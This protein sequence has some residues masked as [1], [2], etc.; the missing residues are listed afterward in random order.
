MK[1]SKANPVI[2]LVVNL[3]E[4]TQTGVVLDAVKLRGNLYKATIIGADAVLYIVKFRLNAP[5]IDQP[6]EYVDI[7]HEY[8]TPTIIN[9]VK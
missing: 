7:V 2:G 8:Y 9:I 5:E 1:K 6:I 3:P 4:S